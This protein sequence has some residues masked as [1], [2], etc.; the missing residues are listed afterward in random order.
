MTKDSRVE[1]YRLA[2]L[3]MSSRRFPV[4]LEVQG[5]DDLAHLGRVLNDLST[6]LERNYREADLLLRITQQINSGFLLEEILS[7]VYDSFQRVIPYER[8]GFSLLEDDGEIL[9]AFWAR[10]SAPTLHITKGYAARMKG[11]SL[12]Q[13]LDT[14][15]PRILNDLEQY[16]ELHRDSDSTRRIVAE[17]MRSSLTCPLVALGK[18]VGFM[19][20][21][22]TRPN[23]YED[24]HVE[25]FERVAGQLA[26]IVEKSRLYQQV[27]DER[28]RSERLLRNILPAS[29][30]DRLKT[31]R[32]KIADGFPDVT[33]LF[34]DLVAFTEWAP[35]MSPPQ[36]VR[37][38]NEVFLEF[39]DLTERH[40]LEKIKTVGD[41]YM[42]AAGLPLPRKDHAAAAVEMALDMLDVVDR[43]R[44]PDG[45]PLRLRVG[46]HSGP[47]VAGVIGR[48]KF[49]YDLWGETVNF[50]SRLESHGVPGRVHVSAATRDL[51][52]ATYGLESHGPVEIK[53][54]GRVETWLVAPRG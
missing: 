41:S 29:I 23:T 45:L 47:V 53:G 31:E 27:L 15:R 8:I 7:Y 5:D 38:L 6:E 30:A 54:V 9:R 13:I 52:G 21:S 49:A 42:V 48:K 33:V 1:Q 4:R 19:F 24:V 25:V 11:S 2:A 12:Q 50:A 35:K 16:L 28:E 39:D 51:L 32:G 37:L 44:R 10:S 34:A 40:D 22:S 14:G 36:L 43:Y 46:V 20:F 26:V 17:G 3:R 18:P